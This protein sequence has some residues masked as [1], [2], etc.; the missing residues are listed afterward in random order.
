MERSSGFPGLNRSHCL[1]L[2]P[3]ILA[4]GMFAQVITSTLTGFVLD[5][6]GAAISGATVSILESRTGF[7]RTTTTDAEGGYLLTGIPAGDYA[8][9]VSED[10]FQKVTRNRQELTQQQSLRVDFNL[11]LGTMQQAVTVEGSAA[12]LDTETAAQASTIDQRQ[13]VS[14]PTMGRSYLGTAILSPGVLP[15]AGDSILNVVYG[16]SQTGGLSFK[17]VSVDVGGGPPDFTG[18]VEDGFNVRDPIYGGDLYQ[19]SPDAITSYRVVQGFDSAQYGGEPTVV[20]ITSKSGTNEYHGSGF[21]FLGNTVLN[22]RTE[23]ATT[24]PPQ[25][26]NQAGV[27][28]GGPV[29]PKL[30]NKSF[31]FASVGGTRNHSASSQLA[32][33]PTAQEWAGNLSALPATIYNPFAANPGT[34]TRDP[35]PGNIIPPTLISSFAQKYQQ[36]VPLPNIANAA[37]GQYNISTLGA[38]VNDDTQYLLRYDQILPKSGQ[39][40]VKFYRDR[41][42]DVAYSLSSYAGLAQP[43]KGMTGSIGWTQP[44]GA[45]SVNEFRVGLFRSVTDYGGVPTSQNIAGSVLGLA[46]V[47]TDP[48]FYGL[49]GVSV[50]GFSVPGTAIYNLHRITTS[51]GINENF[52]SVHGKHTLSVSFLYDPNQWP[53]KNGSFPRGDL[54]FDGSFTRQSPDGTG[55]SA[56]ADFLLGT[57]TTA[58][59]NP[60]S[61]DPFLSTSFWGAHLQD[62]FRV[63]RTLSITLGVR[64][65]YMEPPVEKYNR[66]SAFD[67]DTGQLV[68]A[69]QN[70]LNYQQD[71]TTLSSTSPRGL[72]ENWSKAN[73]SPRFGLAWLVA[74]KT[75]IRAGYGIYYAQGMANFQIFS[76]IGN[77]S[78]PFTNLVTVSNDTSKL[79]PQYLVSQLFPA[80]TVGQVQP[81]SLIA[82]QDIHAP[83]AYVEQ[84]VLSIEHQFGSDVLV[85]AGYHNFLGRHMMDPYD[86]NQASLLN[87]S[88]PLPLQQRRPYPFFSD[89]LL[90]GNNGT[91][92]YNGM[93]LHFEKKFSK[94]F[95]IIANYTWSKSL[96]LFSSEGAGENNQIGTNASLDRGLSDF[97][98]AHYV[99]IGYVWELPF[100]PKKALLNHG[101]TG[102]VARDWRLSGLTQFRSGLPLTPTMPASWPDTAS[103]FIQARPNRVCNGNLSNPTMTEFFDTSCFVDPPPN[104][105]G[106]SGRNVIIGPGSQLWDMSLARGFRFER[107]RFEIRAEAYSVFNHQNWN[108]PDVGVTDSSF[109]EIF[110]KNT[111]RSLQF[112]ARAEF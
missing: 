90:Q 10:G 8:I 105:Y 80:P 111:P 107:F 100:G 39:L 55:G 98:I 33:V 32:I 58:T 88:N 57:F 62:Q 28:F 42:T 75:T 49:P 38:Q 63:S 34:N 53:Q 22:A 74:P 85:S 13:I 77:G 96:D 29:L 76:T 72:F 40:F 19:P 79:T 73:L 71:H 66:M 43:L 103:V 23:G 82:T 50:T 93:Y 60:T 101:F 27:T 36:Y 94:G 89:I 108:S 70:P 30:K 69:L 5:P 25:V 99:V 64:W 41:V 21:W 37:Y 24:T 16:G 87:P 104:S 92:S 3:C 47:N 1:I 12:L 102:E 45:S 14:I 17:P 18:F 7:A 20:Y 84:A 11:P 48:V 2:L 86:I 67:Q 6:G 91:S 112:G 68:Y 54:T 78:P 56:L 109:G 4:A 106:T 31:F 81:G 44:L 15:T 9:T 59:A 51:E 65:D 97:N 52:T 110:G 35:F 95:N 61:F 46:N 26:Y 83:Q